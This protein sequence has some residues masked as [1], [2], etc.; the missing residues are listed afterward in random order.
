MLSDTSAGT[1]YANPITL[2]QMGT[3]SRH[4]HLSGV[5]CSASLKG[6]L[7][8]H[9]ASAPK[10]S[11]TALRKRNAAAMTRPTRNALFEN[12]SGSQPVP[13]LPAVNSIGTRASGNC[14]RSLSTHCRRM[15]AKKKNMPT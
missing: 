6:I 13:A 14:S 4:S 7:S 2:H 12:R 10:S 5:P 11:G 1:R 3:F 15:M 9:A 8:A